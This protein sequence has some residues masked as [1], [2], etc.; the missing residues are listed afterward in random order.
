MKYNAILF[1]LDGTLTDSFEGITRSV[2]YSLNRL[3]IMINSREDL[4]KFIG[5]PLKTSFNEFYGMSGE[6]LSKAIKFYRDRYNDLGWKENAL[7]KDTDIMLKKLYDNGFKLITASSKPKIFVE[8]IL[9]YFKIDK[10][11]YDI[12]GADL[13]GGLQEKSEIIAYAVKK[14]NLDVKKTVMIGD[15]SFDAQGAIDNKLDFIGVLYGFGTDEELS[16]Y[17]NLLLCENAMQIA[18]YFCDEQF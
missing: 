16:K 8:R 10:Y 17:K 2:E 5:P 11:F 6:T 12:C 9:K 13:N 7:Y 15:R 3:G 14:N 4:R 18:T 1:D